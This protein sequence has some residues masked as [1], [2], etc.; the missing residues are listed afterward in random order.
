MLDF[1]LRSCGLVAAMLLTF[2]APSHG[3]VVVTALE[4]GDDVVLDAV[5]TLDLSG[6]TFLG[7][8]SIDSFI[9]PQVGHFFFYTGSSLM[10]SYS[11]ITGPA[12]F[13]PGLFKNADSES[14]SPFGFY[15]SLGFLHAP[16]NYASGGLITSSAVYA[17]STFSS[18]G[19]APGRYTWTWPADSITLRIIP[20]PSSLALFAIGCAVI[21]CRR[22]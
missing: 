14:G 12:S 16:K 1:T 18:L 21:G 7:N 4:V 8:G 15:G 10:D 13:G 19:M 2:A 22:R 6:L 20:E 17:N 3:E 5:G 9:H 11:G